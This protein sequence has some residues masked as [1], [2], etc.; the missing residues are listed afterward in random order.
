MSEIIPYR[1][2]NIIG[3][4]VIYYWALTASRYSPAQ[5]LFDIEAPVLV[6]GI[7]AASSTISCDLS[8]LRS[9]RSSS[10]SVASVGRPRGEQSIRPAL[11]PQ[12]LRRRRARELLL[13]QALERPSLRLADQPFQLLGADS[14]ALG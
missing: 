1:Y 10:C 6:S 12:W 9:P 8:Q 7:A 3:F 4:Y 11:R 14:L 5:A 13:A 2:C